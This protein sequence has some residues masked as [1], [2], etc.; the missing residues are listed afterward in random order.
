M[1]VLD[2]DKNGAR[3]GITTVGMKPGQGF[4]K[5]CPGKT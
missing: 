5:P 2:F 1:G 3:I 4:G